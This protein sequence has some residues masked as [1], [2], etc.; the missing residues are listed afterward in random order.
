MEGP[1]AAGAGA[2]E[3]RDAC[4]VAAAFERRQALEAAAK[5]LEKAEAGGGRRRGWQVEYLVKWVDIEEATWEPAEN[6]DAELVQ[7]FERQQLGNG[8]DAPP[9]ETFAAAAAHGSSAGSRALIVVISIVRL[10]TALAADFVVRSNP[11][12]T[13]RLL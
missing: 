1:D 4:E 6:V 2:G 12:P 7:E 5:E 9:A 11:P 13:S 8:G 10:L 3:G